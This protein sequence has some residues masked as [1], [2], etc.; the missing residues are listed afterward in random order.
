MSTSRKVLVPP[1]VEAYAEVI[2]RGAVCIEPFTVRPIHRNKLRYKVD[3]LAELCFLF[4]YLFFCV[5]TL[6]DVGSAPTNSRLPEASCETW[7]MARTCL[8]C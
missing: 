5:L 7:A 1:V 3:Y 6:G 4:S 8:I 2:E